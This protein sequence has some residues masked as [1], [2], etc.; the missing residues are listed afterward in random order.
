MDIWGPPPTWR[1][2][3]QRHMESSFLLVADSTGGLPPSNT[4]AY[5]HYQHCIS[6]PFSY[7]MLRLCINIGH[8]ITFLRCVCSVQE[9]GSY[10]RGSLCTVAMMKRWNMSPETVGT[11]PFIVLAGGVYTIC[12]LFL[13]YSILIA[14]NIC[15]QMPCLLFSL[16]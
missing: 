8:G 11:H 3:E 1:A 15:I 7:K 9:P 5:H 4:V 13:S 6:F 14:C 2:T 16:V 10:V 12:V